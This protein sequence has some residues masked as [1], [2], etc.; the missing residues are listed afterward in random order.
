MA[1]QTPV[2]RMANLFADSSSDQAPPFPNARRL[3]GHAVEL[4]EMQV[5]LFVSD[6]KAASRRLIWF[7]VLAIVG[8]VVLLGATPVALHAL[9]LYFES[10]FDWSLTAG[11]ALAAGIGAAIGLVLLAVAVVVV[12]T[13][14]AKFSRSANECRQNWDMLKEVISSPSETLAAKR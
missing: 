6:V 3:G 4:G 10:A 1:G 12:R 14:L 2:N 11:L 8:G 7:A 9:G 5:R 13:G